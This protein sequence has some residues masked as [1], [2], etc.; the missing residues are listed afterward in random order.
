MKGYTKLQF[1]LSPDKRIAKAICKY[2]V[3]CLHMKTEKN[4]S[5]TLTPYL[6]LYKKYETKA[7]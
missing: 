7:K 6:K 4:K 2:G 3:F 1:I 5:I